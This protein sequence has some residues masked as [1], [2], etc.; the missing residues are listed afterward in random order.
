MSLQ[1]ENIVVRKK[2]VKNVR[3]CDIAE[4]IGVT[5]NT[6]SKAIRGKGGISEEK[7]KQI[8]ELVK[9]RGYVPNRAAM[10]LRYGRSKM[11][12]IVFDNLINPYYMIMTRMLVDK[13]KSLDYD[14]MIVS[15]LYDCIELKDLGSILGNKVSGIITFVEP[16]EEA[17]EALKN[18]GVQIVLLGRKVFD[19]DVDSISTDDF[20]GGYKVGKY[21]IEKGC[22][23]I[24]YLGAPFMVECAQRRL[25][26]LRKSL[27]ENGIAYDDAWFQFMDSEDM[28]EK[29]EVL[30]Q[31]GVDGVFCFNDI[32]AA[33][34]YKL[35]Q[36]HNL[37]VPE[38]IKIVGYDDVYNEFPMSIKFTSVGSDKKAVVDCAIRLLVSRIEGGA[39][40]LKEHS[41][42]GVFISEGV[43]A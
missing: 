25:A 29:A 37:R 34:F 41:E 6:V 19:I 2:S 8:L 23:R 39:N 17:A 31:N 21:L 10:S 7:R 4:E 35:V 15:G 16:S 14:V 1:K 11:I 40:G 27:D 12:T 30:F 38:D 22:K 13:F 26:G 20:L 43:T 32:M 24:G 5:A 9:E 33:N 36:A 3:L 42:F 18:K 28:T